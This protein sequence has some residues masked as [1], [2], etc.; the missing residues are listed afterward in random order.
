M[1]IFHC[2][3]PLNPLISFL[4]LNIIQSCQHATQT[5][6]QSGHFL[7]HIKSDGFDLPG[8]IPV[9]NLCLP[10]ILLV[11]STLQFSPKFYTDFQPYQSQKSH[12]DWTL[13][14]QSLRCL[15][16][17]FELVRFYPSCTRHGGVKTVWDFSILKK[18]NKLEN[19]QVNLYLKK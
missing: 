5:Q 18:I 17:S 7:V 6:I 14:R 13:K 10:F 3:I 9:Y 19:V 12:R 16:H 15:D 2:W 8:L 1:A 4:H 11:S